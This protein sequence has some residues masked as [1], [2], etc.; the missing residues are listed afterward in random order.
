M[1]L[2]IK[3][4]ESQ[5][6]LLLKLLKCLATEN[7]KMCTPGWIPEHKSSFFDFWTFLGDQSGIES[8]CTPYQRHCTKVSKNKEQVLFVLKSKLKRA[9]LVAA[10]FNSF[11][12]KLFCDSKT[13]II[14]HNSY[15]AQAFRVL[16]TQNW[17]KKYNFSWA[18]IR[19]EMRYWTESRYIGNFKPYSIQHVS[20]IFRRN[21]LEGLMSG[22]KKGK[23][24]SNLKQEKCKFVIRSHFLK[25]ILR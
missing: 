21:C 12:S 4:F 1:W 25:K 20:L 16:I 9:F 14:S 18:Y 17:K 6:N 3:G 19:E 8:H 15:N 22:H 13:V 7:V 5:N 23:I 24:H 2:I 11:K 10:H